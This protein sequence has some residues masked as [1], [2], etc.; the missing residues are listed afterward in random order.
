MGVVPRRLIYVLGAV[1]MVAALAL[2]LQ[3][4]SSDSPSPYPPVGATITRGFAVWPADTV[5]EARTECDEASDE[6][7]RTDPRA[8]AHQFGRDVLG[9]RTVTG[10]DD[11]SHDDAASYTALIL[12]GQDRNALGSALDLRRFGRCWYVVGAQPREGA[13]DLGVTTIGGGRTVVLGEV[14]PGADVRI[15]WGTWQKTLGGGRS[16]HHIFL[17]PPPAA[18]GAPGHFI[19]THPDENGYSEGVDAY[20]LPAIP[21]GED[22]DPAPPSELPLSTNDR[23]LCKSPYATHGSPEAVIRRL[24]TWDLR[25]G[26]SL[27]ATGYQRYRVAETTRLSKLA[28]RVRLDEADLRFRFGRVADRCWL[29]QEIVPASG[30]LID[31]LAIGAKAVT[32]RLHAGAADE[33]HVNGP[34]GSRRLRDERGLLTHPLT[35]SFTRDDATPAAGPYVVLAV[36]YEN[37]RLASAE[38]KWFDPPKADGN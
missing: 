23:A 11:I 25:S 12:D 1:G 5:A 36:A 29:L 7:W 28:W 17:R 18:Y 6:S 30:A 16:G 32:V 26:L 31:G 35:L 8:T 27:N 37:G 13:G 4:V 22:A 2:V 24:K 3:I 33:V 34:G 38:L 14:D 15:G 10:G 9:Y 19:V 21:T 20:P